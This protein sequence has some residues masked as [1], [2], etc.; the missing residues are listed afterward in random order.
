[1]TM[2]S[3]DYIT[4]KHFRSGS[5]ILVALTASAAAGLSAYL[6]IMNGFHPWIAGFAGF[7]AVSALFTLI[8]LFSPA[9]GCTLLRFSAA[10]NALVCFF[11]GM[12]MFTLGYLFISHT[13]T[14]E[15]V[16][17]LLSQLGINTIATQPNVTGTIL[18]IGSLMLYLAF[19]CAFFAHRYLGAARS[20]A[21][22][23][24][25]R[26]GFRVFPLTSC[27]LFL[28][29]SIAAA[30]FLFLSPGSFTSEMLSD[31]FMRTS[32]LLIVVLLL[33]LLFS[34]ICARSFAHKSFAF[35]VFEKQI[36][37]VETNADGTVYVP[38]NEDK[39]PGEEEPL[40]PSKKQKKKEEN[41]KNGKPFISD[42]PSAANESAF[43]SE[44]ESDI[45]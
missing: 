2:N 45:L 9:T 22:G 33:H 11:S 8:S 5:S 16:N 28:A 38:I 35:K 17:N 42:F 31:R 10:I 13:N 43:S 24:L 14:Q 44:G 23:T 12:G 29:A 36:M 39:D 15:H 3:I 26:N 27:I 6:S 30:G 4:K 21:S 19:G 40:L 18:L 7:A 32:A 25:K 1:M 34:G 41:P 20:C 37:K